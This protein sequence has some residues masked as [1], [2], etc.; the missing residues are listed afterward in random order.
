MYDIWISQTPPSGVKLT[1][2]DYTALALSLALKSDTVTTVLKQQQNRITNTDRKDRL[3]FLM[4]ALS[5]D[6][7]ERDA[8]F[9][10]LANQ[11]NRAK[12]AWVTTALAYLH[13]PI[14]QNASIKY[15]PKSL[16][17]VEEIQRTGDI[18]FPQSWLS[19]IFGNY[20]TK[21]AYQTVTDFLNKNPKYNPKLKEKILQTTD[22]LCRAQQMLS[23]T[24]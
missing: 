14:R 8:F 7:R 12:E 4:P 13:H 19:A 22:N 2:D 6:V 20:Q 15:L 16:E 5:L 17:L 24:R 18:F 21:E 23:S 9:D 10:G 1:E 11:K 3:N